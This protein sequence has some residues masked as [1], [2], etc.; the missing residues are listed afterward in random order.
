MQP[1]VWQWKCAISARQPAT[2]VLHQ[3]ILSRVQL[4]PELAVRLKGDQCSTNTLALALVV[5]SVQLLIKEVEEAYG[6]HDTGSSFVLEN[7]LK[8]REKVKCFDC[9]SGELSSSRVLVVKFIELAS[10]RNVATV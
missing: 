6:L 9:F 1:T 8:N 10:M 2:S 4:Q 7:K 3:P 5:L